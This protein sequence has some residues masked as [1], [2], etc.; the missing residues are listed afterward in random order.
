M[1]PSGKERSLRGVRGGTILVVDPAP[2]ARDPALAILEAALAQ[3]DLSGFSAALKV[4]ADRLGAVG[5]ILWELAPGAVLEASEPG[6]RLFLLAQSFATREAYAAHDLPLQSA[7]GTAILTGATV[8]V[9]SVREDPRV[10]R[11]AAFFERNGIVSLCA[12]PLAIEA[13]VRGALNFYFGPGAFS[14]AAGAESERLGRLFPFVYRATT[15]RITRRLLV[16]LNEVLRR[17]DQSRPNAAAE[18]RAATQAV[19]EVCTALAEAFQC[20]EAAVILAPRLDE[21]VEFRLMRTTHKRP[22]GRVAWG[23]DP[24]EGLTA[25]VLSHSAPMLIPDLRRFLYDRDILRR[26]YPGLRWSG[27][28]ALEQD[29]RHTLELL[30][31]DP[32]PPLTFMAA[33][34]LWGGRVLGVV[35][36][37]IARGGRGAFSAREA[38]TLALVAGELG[39][40]WANRLNRHELDE[41]NRSW[42]RLV[43]GLA[44]LN[45]FGH[46]EL[47][48][49]APD[50]HAIF[51][52]AL[53]AV[54]DVIRDAQ[55]NDVRV[56]EPGARALVF[57][58]T[59]GD[60]WRQGDAAAVHERLAKHFPLDGSSAAAEVVRT[61][62]TYVMPDVS[63]DRHYSV[64]FPEVKRMVIAPLGLE[65]QPF[66][67]L[68]IRGTGRRSFSPYEVRIAELLGQQIGLYHN[69][70]ATIRRA[71]GA[72][73]AAAREAATRIE[74][75]KDLTHQLKGPVLQAYLRAQAALESLPSEEAAGLDAHRVEAMRLRLF[76]IRGLC[77]KAK[78]VTLGTHL[79]SALASGTHVTARTLPLDESK[80]VKLLVEAARDNEL[81]ATDRGIRFHVELDALRSGSRLADYHVDY[82]LLEQAVNNLLD[83]AAK[84]SYENTPVRVTCGF[85]RSDRFSISVTNRGIPLSREDAQSCRHRAWRGEQAKW[86]T[87]EGT[88]LGLWVVDNIMHALGGELIALPTDDG[89]TE[90][91]LLFP[92]HARKDGSE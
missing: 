80:L 11:D 12:V 73:Q 76:A 39:R 32:L 14:D 50:E 45:R 81:V 88:G 19:R 68:D 31:G 28:S 54:S 40:W 70:G 47:G 72:E 85:T 69:L 17:A 27:L 35:R 51:E 20:L 67:V 4:A 71:R 30:R 60:A 37:G 25:W 77:G 75:S 26:E 15:D 90:F 57:A 65:E 89:I 13:G 84:Y 41:E 5:A 63:V 74:A 33:P 55:I 53:E 87:G 1:A 43:D 46:A 2:A 23:K 91:K 61:G 78:R 49:S 7:T 9:D 16:K 58:A 42:R 22:G 10:H 3:E 24:G 64:I 21:P 82:E 59:H 38:R 86:V 6:G 36:C 48:R 62:R 56:I 66:G 34:I 92:P 29:V 8:T 83:N 79:Y 18:T 44:Q 52:K